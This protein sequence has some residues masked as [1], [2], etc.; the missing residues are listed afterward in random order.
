MVVKNQ[1]HVVNEMHLCMKYQIE[2]NKSPH[3][4]NK[5]FPLKLL[6]PTHGEF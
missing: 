2:F 3:K 6:Y 1:I 4:L 5:R